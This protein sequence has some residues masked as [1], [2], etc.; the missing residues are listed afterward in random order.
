[1]RIFQ[2]NWKK[3]TVYGLIGLAL[4]YAYYFFIGCQSGSCPLTGNPYV[5]SGYGLGAGIFLALEFGKKE[6]HTQ[7]ESDA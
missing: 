2:Q 1:M 4:G 6:K 7:K 5:S 3:I